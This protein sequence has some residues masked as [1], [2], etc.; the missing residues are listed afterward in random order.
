MIENISIETEPHQY[1]FSRLNLEYTVMS[2]RKL[3]ALVVENLRRF[4]KTADP[5]NPIPIIVPNANLAKWL[6]LALSRRQSV[7]FNGH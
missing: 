6:Q 4:S 1:E 5:F 2:K 3:M 7:V